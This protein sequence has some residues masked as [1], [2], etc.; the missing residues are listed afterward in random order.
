MSEEQ[1]KSKVYSWIAGVLSC[2]QKQ[3]EE[4]PVDQSSEQLD[5]TSSSD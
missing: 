4:I 1:P 3:T 2:F 5:N